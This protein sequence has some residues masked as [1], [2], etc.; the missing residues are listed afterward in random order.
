MS[1]ILIN[2][3]EANSPAVDLGMHMAALMDAPLLLLKVVKR[4]AQREEAE[5][6]L[7]G[8]AA[9]LDSAALPVRVL[10]GDLAGALMAACR[11]ERATLLVTA[12]REG[13]GL[14]ARW[15]R[16]EL[17][18]LCVDAPCA[19]LMARGAF[20]PLRS[21]LL[22]EGGD[23]ER[24][25]LKRLLTQLPRLVQPDQQLSVLHVM[26][27]ISILPGSA[28]WQLVADVDTLIGQQTH[29]GELLQRDVQTLSQVKT[30]SRPVIRHG[31]VVDEILAESKNGDYDLIIIGAHQ[32]QG[33][34]AMLLSNIAA[35][36]VE[37]MDRPLLIIR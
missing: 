29:E 17:L 21:M 31:L 35:D 22:C 15:Q 32:K 24:P 34:P 10:V 4:P 11:Q 7:R 28:D 5:A 27:Q 13:D 20:R 23:V 3:Q 18:Q 33:W 12:R 37:Q 9:R 6:M 14:G 26:S 25:L 8:L 30:T 19:V 36:L 1:R 16:K 2:V